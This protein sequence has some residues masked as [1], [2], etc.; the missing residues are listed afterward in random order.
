MPCPV[1]IMYHDSTSNDEVSVSDYIRRYPTN[2][3]N[4]NDDKYLSQVRVT[5]NNGVVICV[6]RHPS[7]QWLV[8]FGQPGGCFNYN[9]V[10]NGTNIQWVGQTNLTSYLLPPTNGWVVFSPA[11]PKI[12][13][14]TA[15]NGTISL[16][17][18]NLLPGFSN[19]VECATNLSAANWNVVNTFVLSGGP[20]TNL[21]QVATDN[22]PQ[23]F[24]RI[25]RLLQ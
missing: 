18:T 11:P 19:Y 5:Y 13:S 12:S 2:Y 10:M 17:V 25:V 23:A 7:R 3:A 15:T 4:Q 20:Q 1:S 9:A 22:W 6:N 24:F 21:V 14:I 16:S 8:Q